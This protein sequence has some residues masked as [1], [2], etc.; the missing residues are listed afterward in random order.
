MNKIYQYE[1]PKEVNNLTFSVWNKNVHH[2]HALFVGNL[3]EIFHFLK[4]N[5][6]KKIEVSILNLRFVESY[7]S[8]TAEEWLEWYYSVT[9]FLPEGRFFIPESLI[10]QSTKSYDLCEFSDPVTIGIN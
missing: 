6:I 10:R 4:N 9:L 2:G 5:N 1:I 3:V 7:D 8:L